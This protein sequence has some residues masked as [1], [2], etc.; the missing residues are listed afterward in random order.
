MDFFNKMLW[1][2]SLFIAVKISTRN[3][4]F[5]YLRPLFRE[6]ALRLPLNDLPFAPAPDC[7]SRNSRD[8][9]FT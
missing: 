2:R 1:S 4:N 9:G 7:L 5:S 6:E 3:S 8:L